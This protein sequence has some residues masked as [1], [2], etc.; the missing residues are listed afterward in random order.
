MVHV[1]TKERHNCVKCMGGIKR[2]GGLSNIMQ[3]E[4]AEGADPL[5]GW[6]RPEPYCNPDYASKKYCNAT[7]WTD[8]TVLPTGEIVELH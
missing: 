6:R 5:S 8:Y 7:L 1:P 3:F 2:K 4:H